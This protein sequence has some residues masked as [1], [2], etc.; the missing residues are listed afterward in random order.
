MLYKTTF[1]FL[2]KQI[3]SKQSMNQS[4]LIEDAKYLV[5]AKMLYDKYNC[6]SATDLHDA[7]LIY[8]ESLR[9][10]KSEWVVLQHFAIPR[11]VIKSRL[12]IFNND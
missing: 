8:I 5:T 10:T 6:K 1:M 3:I 2:F 7:F 12:S 4:T 11:S 9:K